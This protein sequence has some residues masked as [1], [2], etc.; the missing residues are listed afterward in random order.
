MQTELEPGRRRNAEFPLLNP[1][2]LSRP[3]IYI[4][5]HGPKERISVGPEGDSPRGLREFGPPARAVPTLYIL[6]RCSGAGLVRFTPF[7][8][9][10]KPHQDNIELYRKVTAFKIGLFAKQAKEQNLT[11]LLFGHPDF[12][13]PPSLP[14]SGID[15][16]PLPI[17]RTY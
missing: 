14:L 16:P 7:L 15:K 5:V 8:G 11:N 3:C 9:H 10:R 4:H 17:C 2:I 1:A 6:S 13:K 12:D